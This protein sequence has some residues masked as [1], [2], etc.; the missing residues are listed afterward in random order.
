MRKPVTT[1]PLDRDVAQALISLQLVAHGLYV[2]ATFE[3][4]SSCASF[5]QD[6]CPHHGTGPCKCRL[7]VLQIYDGKSGSLQLI[8]HEFDGKTEFILD[9]EGCSDHA[10]LESRV[11]QA[12]R[13][14]SS[15][16]GSFIETYSSK[17]A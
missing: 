1:L 13:E 9:Q 10:D 14:E 16:I 17:N 12:I 2:T 5:T 8:L 15:A 4:D 11:K 6:K 7:S 3:L